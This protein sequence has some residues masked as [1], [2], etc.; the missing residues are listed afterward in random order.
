[1]HQQ[2]EHSSGSKLQIL[3]TTFVHRNEIHLETLS[4]NVATVFSL[5]EGAQA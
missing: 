2:P 4:H 5:M 1:M 3:K